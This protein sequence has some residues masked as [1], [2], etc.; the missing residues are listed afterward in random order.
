[1]VKI[2]KLT[3]K[4]LSADQIKPYKDRLDVALS[5]ES[6]SGDNGIKNIAVTGIYGSGKSSVIHSYFDNHSSYNKK[7]LYVSL[8]NHDVKVKMSEKQ[9]EDLQERILNQIIHQIPLSKIVLS[10]VTLRRH[11]FRKFSFWTKFIGMSI[12]IFY[13]LYHNL[14]FLLIF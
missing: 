2:Q 3:Y 14:M 8:S 5:D 11:F 12:L 7:V 10:R 1:M 4:S 13:G 9:L 6:A